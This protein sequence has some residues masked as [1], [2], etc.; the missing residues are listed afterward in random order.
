MSGELFLGLVG[1]A[2][3]TCFTPGPNNTMLLASGLNFGW[4]RSV[5]HVLGVAFGFAFMVLAVGLGVGQVFALFPGL[6]NVLRVASIT[7]LLWL[8][9]GIA[10]AGT[11]SEEAPGARPLT[12]LEAALF[13]WINP[14]AWIMARGATTTYVSASAFTLSVAIMAVTFGVVGFGSSASWTIFGAGLKRLLQRPDLVRWL[15][16][17]MA[18]MLVVSLWPV[19]ADLLR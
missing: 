12:V 18:A 4:T 2:V 19:V 5:P 1:F 10:T 15:N 8:A 13:Q 7:Y 16:V 17:A 11:V 14:K 3:I 9:W 6:Y